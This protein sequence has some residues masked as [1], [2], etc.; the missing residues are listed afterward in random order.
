M[1]KRRHAQ[2]V[3]RSA[4]HSTM[5][6]PFRAAA[7]PVAWS[8]VVSAVVLTIAV[9]PVYAGPAGHA[10]AAPGDQIPDSGA[11]PVPAGTLQLPGSGT[12]ISTKPAL[13]TLAGQ[14]TAA[15]TELERT[16]EQLKQLNIERGTL[17]TNLALADR[18]WRTATDRLKKAEEQVGAD[19]AKAFKV[20]SGLP[21]GLTSELRSLGALSAIPDD[22]IPGDGAARELT[23]AEQD[24]R[25]KYEAYTKAIKAEQDLANQVLALQE[26]YK[27]KEN[28]FLALRQRNADQ[29]AAIERE[30][31]GREQRLGEQYIDNGSLNGYAAN[32]KALDAVRMALKQLGKPYVWGAEGPR[33]FDCSGLMWYSYHH[34]AKY[35]LP[36]V[37][38][39]QYYRT[40]SRTVSRYAMLPGDLIFFAT[41][42]ND[43]TTV[44]HVGMYVGGGK[45]VHAPNTGDVVKI[46][47]V[48][49]SEFF[50]VTRVFQE[51][52]GSGG[53]TTTPPSS[54]NPGG[55]ST[56]SPKPSPKPSSKPSPKPTKTT[57]PSPTPSKTT[58]PSPTSSTGPSPTPA[59]EP[60]VTSK[61][62]TSSPSGTES[63]GTESGSSGPSGASATT[64]SP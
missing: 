13:S 44:H 32:P 7:R 26:D 36:R 52:R 55:G 29:L 10:Y 37:A 35:D 47:T 24:E 6:S 19:A 58:S 46:S 31:E 15:Q 21:A 5:R 16:G 34:G 27:R 33:S 62:P 4:T 28:A 51:V 17:R 63:S 41:N 40:R 43:W 38:R 30:R 20:T 64:D 12:T 8:A 2:A 1:A 59:P 45:M 23:L 3:S 49:W 56:S 22:D 54:G 60:S 18:D 53:S 9:G 11:R 42:P 39:D 48:W 50:A 57:S 14:I 61:S 25:V